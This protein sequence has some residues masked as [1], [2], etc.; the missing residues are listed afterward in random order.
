MSDRR[1]VLVI[2][3]G[4]GDD[5]PIYK[6]FARRW[7]RLGFEC[8]IVAFGWANTHAPLPSTLDTFLQRLDQ[9]QADEL[10]IIGISAGGTAAVNA[11][12][13][14]PYVKKII[15]VCSPLA[16]MPG[17]RNPLLG[18]SINRLSSGLPQ[19][20]AEQ[21]RRILS[22]YGSHDQ[23]VDIR[24]SQPT[25]VQTRKLQTMLHAPTIYIAMQWYARSLSRFFR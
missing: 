9:L 24:L 17:L 11:L 12:M 16:A 23:V 10:Y 19:L 18:A 14:R 20:S 22:V 6:K 15:T 7:Q 21:K 2:V 1:P 5:T 3:P 4:I 13:A 25:G 8:H